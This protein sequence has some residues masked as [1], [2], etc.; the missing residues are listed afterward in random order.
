MKSVGTVA[1]PVNTQQVTASVV[2]NPTEHADILDFL[3][4]CTALKPKRLKIDDLRWR[5]A[6]RAVLR[7]ENLMIR[8]DSGC[9]KTLLATTV[10]DI[11]GRPFFFFNLGATQDPR[12]TLIG[13]THFKKDEGTYVA[14]ALFVKAIQ[15]PNA[16]L[17]L[18]EVSRA[19]PDAH[20]ILM[21]VLD[22]TQRYLR[23]DER[24]DTPTIKVAG[25][26]T[27]LSTA[28]VGAEYTATRTMDRAF[29]DRWTILLM[30]PLPKEQE[31]ELLTEMFPTL[32]PFDVDGIAE[33]AAETR[34]QVRSENP[35]VSTIVSTRITTQMAALLYDGFSLAEAAEV[36][37]YPFYSDAG[38]SEGERT[39][40]KQLVQR[41]VRDD[42]N[43][44]K[45]APF[46]PMGDPNG[47]NKKPW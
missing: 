27:F 42:A 6:V 26:V 1:H 34:K 47:G 28:N 40:M 36:K 31:I 9:G 10:A 32:D 33:I 11:L 29:V 39:Y 46:S 14:E 38:G 41:F 3:K 2:E 18:D 43:M 21:S 22:Q 17:L 24:P 4:K 13:N 20:N 12:S 45:T 7:G 8:G 25:G 35:K 44:A 30:D 37:I 19:H 23:I 5:F 15:T 16:V